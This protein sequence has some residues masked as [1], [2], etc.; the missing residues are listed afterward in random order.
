M[1]LHL[2]ALV[3]AERVARVDDVEE[4]VVDLPHVVQQRAHAE[5]RQLA[6]RIRTAAPARS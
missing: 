1:E 2:R 3:L 5:R 4:A 6:A